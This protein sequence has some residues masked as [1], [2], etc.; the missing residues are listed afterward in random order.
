MNIGQMFEGATGVFKASN[1]D[2]AFQ[3]IG[4][5]TRGA[6]FG[7]NARASVMRTGMPAGMRGTASSRL[8]ALAATNA[9]TGR[10]VVAGGVAA[11]GLGMANRKGPV[12]GYNPRVPVVKVPPH[13]R[14]M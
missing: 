13:G 6:L 12:G 2:K 7:R 8:E 9:K 1:R 5:K 10:R 11:G 4:K 14:A 3:F